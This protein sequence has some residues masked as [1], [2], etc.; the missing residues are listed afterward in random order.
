MPL[1][2]MLKNVKLWHMVNDTFA[3]WPLQ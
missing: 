2:L 3:S 1:S